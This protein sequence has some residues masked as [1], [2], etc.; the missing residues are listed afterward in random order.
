MSAPKTPKTRT[1][2]P[3]TH[4]DTA[5]RWTTSSAMASGTAVPAPAWPAQPTVAKRATP[6]T[7]PAAF[8]ATDRS[9]P[10][11]ATNGTATASTANRH[12]DA[13]P[14]RVSSTAEMVD[15]RNASPSCS[16]AAYAPCN[17]SVRMVATPTVTPETSRSRRARSHPAGHSA[18]TNETPPT[19]ITTAPNSTARAVPN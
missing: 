16:P 17:A 7:A 19:N 12:S 9:G 14:Y 18:T 10:A 8:D 1:A 5:A 6:T 2:R 3:P 15:Q 11:T 13:A 4:T